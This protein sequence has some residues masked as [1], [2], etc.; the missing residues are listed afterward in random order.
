M[1][2]PDQKKGFNCPVSKGE[3]LQNVHIISAFHSEFGLAH[4][5]I[6]LKDAGYLEFLFIGA[7]QFLYTY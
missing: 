5:N 7:K 3:E 4:K 2:K 6:S 1:P